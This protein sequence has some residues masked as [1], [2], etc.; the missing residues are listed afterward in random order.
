MSESGRE[1]SILPDNQSA[2][3]PDNGPSAQAIAS[4]PALGA[5]CGASVTIS[6]EVTIS[7]GATNNLGINR[8]RQ[9]SIHVKELNGT[10]N[11]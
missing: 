7:G 9:P 6:P 11:I 8:E 3:A 4:W 10:K 2:E 1:G 5:S